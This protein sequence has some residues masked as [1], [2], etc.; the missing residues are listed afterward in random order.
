MARACLN[1]SQLL[2]AIRTEHARFAATIAA[3]DPSQLHE[4]GLYDDNDWTVKDVVAHVVAWEQM[5]VDWLH[6]RRLGGTPRFQ[7][8]DM[9]SRTHEL[10]DLFHAEHKDRPMPDVM[11]DFERSYEQVIQEIEAL[12]D[13]AITSDEPFDPVTQRPLFPHIA[14]N[15]FE[16][17][18]DHTGAMQAWLRRTEARS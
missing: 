18:A 11:A 9:W 2:D 12:P 7:P 16:H 15:T 6:T 1:K 8:N 14:V 4:P 3:V 10:N 13:E 5:L 17:Y